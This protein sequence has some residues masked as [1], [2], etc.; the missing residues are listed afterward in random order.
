MRNHCFH[1]QQ[2]TAYHTYISCCEASEKS[3]MSI[4]QAD[5]IESFVVSLGDE[6][7]RIEKAKFVSLLRALNQEDH[8]DNYWAEL[9]DFCGCPA[10]QTS[11]G[12]RQLEKMYDTEEYRPDTASTNLIAEL[13]KLFRAIDLD[14][15]GE[16]T[17]EEFQRGEW[18]EDLRKELEQQDGSSSTFDDL[19]EQTMYRVLQAADLDGDG[20]LDFTDFCAA[21][22]KIDQDSLSTLK[23]VGKSQV[24]TVKKSTHHHKVLICSKLDKA[25]LKA[26]ANKILSDADFGRRWL[27]GLFGAYPETRALFSADMQATVRHIMGMLLK[28]ID[29][30]DHFEEMLPRLQRLGVKHVAMGI[31]LE[32]VEHLLYFVLDTLQCDL[33]SEESKM[34]VN[35]F[36]VIYYT[37]MSAEDVPE[38]MNDATL[39][40][41]NLVEGVHA[42]PLLDPNASTAT[43]FVCYLRQLAQCHEA[44]GD[45]RQIPRETCPTWTMLCASSLTSMP[46]TEP[47]SPTT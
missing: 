24:V 35:L 41:G 22:L 38:L 21:V 16:V 46:L 42:N 26:G 31:K 5:A 23:P 37:M 28:V 25:V 11:I 30:V 18:R 8:A 40:V 47:A 19:D 20:Q 43:E 39:T 44:V 15:N 3:A 12:I 14:G 4:T 29:Q 33:E 10:S 1:Q 17:P 7:D 9:L 2:P 13:Q 45:S 6:G 32:Y 27:T 36:A 34:W